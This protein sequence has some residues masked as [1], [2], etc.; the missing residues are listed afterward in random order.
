MAQIFDAAVEPST[1]GYALGAAA[2][3]WDLYAR[4]V[5]QLQ[6]FTMQG[7]TAPSLS[8]SG[9]GIIYFDSSANKFKVSENGGAYAT[10]VG[11]FPPFSDA[12]T[13]VVNS[14]DATKLAIFSAASITTGTTRTYTLPNG[15][16]TLAGINLAQTW[17][18][19]QTH[20]AHIYPTGDNLYSL[21]GYGQGWNAVIGHVIG[22]ENLTVCQS[23]MASPVNSWAIQMVDANTMKITD[24]L[25]VIQSQFVGSGSTPGLSVVGRVF[26]STNNTRTLGQ[27]SLRWSTTYTQ[28]L[29]V[30]GSVS[31]NLVPTGSVNLGSTANPWTNITAG[32]IRSNTLLAVYDTGFTTNWAFKQFGGSTAFALYDNGGTVRF[33]WS[34]S[35]GSGSESVTSYA[36]ITP[37]VTNT[38]QVGTTATRWKQF[39]AGII[40]LGITSGTGGYFEMEYTSS[41]P[42]L[43]GANTARMY[44]DGT[45]IKV[46]KAGGAYAT[47]I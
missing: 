9:S 3:T 10:L 18:A 33:A 2:R 7:I 40:N 8:T 37:D 12:N 44:F 46:S 6:R 17:T 21:G 25:G 35:A 4:Y 32:D 26:P 31:S 34:T 5:L 11:S 22:T 29:D 19:Q 27:S 15:N 38:R 43:S 28:N 1:T 45:N 30:A 13:L 41:P 42:S 20:T 39:Y 23:G 36:H 47:L 16:V 14:S 24:N